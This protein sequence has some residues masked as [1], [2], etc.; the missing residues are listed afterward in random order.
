MGIKVGIDLGTTN[1]AISYI[2]DGKPVI[3]ENKEGDRTTPSAV[4]EKD[5]QL[6][7]GKQA[8]NAIVSMP[9]HVAIEAKRLMGTDEKI[10]LGSKS[11]RSEEIA[12]RILK[13]LIASAEERTGEK[14]EEA[15]ITVPA[16]FNDTQRRGF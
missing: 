1:S 7:V 13:Y 8:K 14:V 2:K 10:T 15:I 6:I 5:S 11:Y 12:S 16:Y 9:M 4:L 3:I